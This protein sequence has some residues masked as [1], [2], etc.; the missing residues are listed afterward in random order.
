MKRQ[1]TVK[2]DGRIDTDNEEETKAFIVAEARPDREGEWGDK[3]L[4]EKAGLMRKAA[5]NKGR[6]GDGR[7]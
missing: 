4:C 2:A 1:L 5:R 3:T 7:V 6:V